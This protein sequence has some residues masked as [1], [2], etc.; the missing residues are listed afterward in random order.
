[1]RA[2]YNDNLQVLR[3][4]FARLLRATAGFCKTESKGRTANRPYQLRLVFHSKGDGRALYASFDTT[5]RAEI[6]RASCRERVCLYV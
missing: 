2:L 5:Y 1:M 3:C 4:R 6:G